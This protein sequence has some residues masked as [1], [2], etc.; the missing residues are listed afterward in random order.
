MN[1]HKI[2]CQIS[3]IFEFGSSMSQTKY[4]LA[5]VVRI[6]ALTLISYTIKALL[7]YEITA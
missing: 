3:P 4:Q 6:P 5:F 2:K 7:E 1:G